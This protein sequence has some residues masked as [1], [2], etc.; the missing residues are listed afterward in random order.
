MGAWK[1][2]SEVD[3]EAERVDRQKAAVGGDTLSKLKDLN[4]LIIGCRGV[5]TETAKNLILSN[6][7]A[8]GVI[9]DAVCCTR[10]LG[11]NCY[12]SADDVSLSR[13]RSAAVLP[14]LKSLNP[15]CKVEIFPSA[16]NAAVS[17]KNFLGT[18]RP[19]SA[20]V[21]TVFTAKS[22]VIRLDEICRK[23]NIAFI[24]AVNSGVTSFVFSDFGPNHAI[25]DKNGNPVQV[26]R[27]DV[28]IFSFFFTLNSGN[29][30]CGGRN[31][32]FTSKSQSP[33]LQG[34]RRSGHFDNAEAS[35]QSC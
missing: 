23:E 35:Q 7:G 4:V 28:S 13:S 26:K 18:N 19:I 12:I 31:H 3:K 9:D 14:Q 2:G 22:E 10:D 8:V 17:T 25:S 24:F 6:V 21:L 32:E 1:S 34:G 27:F 11:A 15:F 20:I 33:R 29:S 30:H 5:G 16:D